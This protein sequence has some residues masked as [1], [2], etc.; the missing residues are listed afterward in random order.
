MVGNDG[1][2]AV[3][4]RLAHF[5]SLPRGAWAARPFFS[6]TR[7]IRAEPQGAWASRPLLFSSKGGTGGS[8]VFFT[9]LF[10]RALKEFRP[11]EADQSYHGCEPRC[12]EIPRSLSLSGRSIAGQKKISPGFTK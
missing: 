2:P 4:V 9:V 11:V 8:P 1:F 3:V 5:F 10:P 6:S 12:R 7:S